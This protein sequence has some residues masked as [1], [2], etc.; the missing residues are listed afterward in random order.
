MGQNDFQIVP[1]ITGI[2]CSNK[3]ALKQTRAVILQ[4]PTAPGRAQIALYYA[5]IKKECGFKL[6]TD[7]DDLQWDLSPVIASYAKEIPNHDQMMQASLKQVLPL[8][9]VVVCSTR[10]LASRIKSDLGVNAVVMPNGISQSLFGMNKRTSAFTGKPKVMYLDTEMS[11]CHTERTR[12]RICQAAGRETSDKDLLVFSLKKMTV[13]E[14]TEF[15]Q[16]LLKREGDVGL[17]ILDGVRDLVN[18]V[19]DNTAA[20]RIAEMVEK[21]ADEFGIH[22]I[23]TLHLNKTDKSPRGH[24]GT[25][26]TAKAE[27][28]ILL[29]KEKH[30]DSTKVSPLE[31][32]DVEFSPFFMTVS[33]DGL[34]IKAK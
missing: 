10:Y 9:D 8:F 11:R 33:E 34:P 23:T 7:L 3:E 24:L 28:L 31:L 21:W 13:E 17:V 26:V 1:S 32:R 22:L 19:N 29:E 20:H 5:K 12:K 2:I 6:V 18:D 30:E 14:R 16:E 4:K 15:L 27:S 25:E